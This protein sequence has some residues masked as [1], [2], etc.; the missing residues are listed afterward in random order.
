MTQDKGK[1]PAEGELERAKDTA[2]EIVG[3]IT[4]VDGKGHCFTVSENDRDWLADYIAAHTKIECD[5]AKETTAAWAIGVIDELHLT[6]P[7][8]ADRTYK[9]IKNTL[10]DRFKAITGVDP[11][12][13]YPVKATLHPT[14]EQTRGDV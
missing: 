10:R 5:K 8:E 3:R 6:A 4:L 1:S 12:P 11:A 9:G 13:N 2:D 14:K 7:P